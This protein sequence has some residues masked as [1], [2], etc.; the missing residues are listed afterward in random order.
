MVSGFSLSA[1]HAYSSMTVSPW[2]VRSTG[3][4]LASGGFGS[5]VS[6]ASESIDRLVPWV[7]RC[8]ARVSTCH[9]HG[10]F[11]AR[12]LQKILRDHEAGVG[13]S[14]AGDVRVRSGAA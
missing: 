3:M 13:G 8:R 14:F 4:R 7:A 5:A 6:I 11:L 9:D 10:G 12:G 1:S 2:C